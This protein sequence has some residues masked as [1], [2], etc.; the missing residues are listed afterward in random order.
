MKQVSHDDVTTWLAGQ[1][2]S[3][4]SRQLVACQIISP[5]EAFAGFTVFGYF[6][7]LIQSHSRSTDFESASNGTCLS[8]QSS[9]RDE[10]NSFDYTLPLC[11]RLNSQPSSEEFTLSDVWQSP[12]LCCTPGEK[13]CDSLQQS[14]HDVDSLSPKNEDRKTCQPNLDQLKHVGGIQDELKNDAQ[15]SDKNWSE[16]DSEIMISSHYLLKA[17]SG[18]QYDQPFDSSC[19]SGQNICLDLE[20]A[21]LSE[22]V[23]DFVSVEPQLSEV[24]DAKQLTFSD[25]QNSGKQ[26]ANNEMLKND[27]PENLKITTNNAEIPKTPKVLCTTRFSGQRKRNM[28]LADLNMNFSPDIVH[29]P[30]DNRLDRKDLTLQRKRLT[31][32]R[33][34]VAF[35]S[36]NHE[37]GKYIRHCVESEIHSGKCKVKQEQILCDDHRDTYNCSA[38]LFVSCQN[39]TD[40]DQSD[41]REIFKVNEA[42]NCHTSEPGVSGAL[43]FSP[44]LQSTPVSYQHA[45]RQ[46]TERSR[47]RVESLYS[48]R[49]ELEFNSDVPVLKENGQNKP[50]VTMSEMDQ[51]QIVDATERFMDKSDVQGNSSVNLNEW[52]RDL[53]E[54]SF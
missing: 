3:L 20:N 48:K 14:G 26:N 54:N 5:S 41:V 11:A 12:G 4:K 52:S 38:D 25:K 24:T 43:P 30:K 9:Q 39:S 8:Q 51:L 19:H 36:L 7:N 2:S 15:S 21:P 50:K 6:K 13:S 45:F 33:L 29:P 10:L 22:N 28:I 1:S 27:C 34:S 42:K 18:E 35:C 37:E 16:N 47:V 49:L 53:F 40:M 17:L 23:L 44:R 31:R 32:H 46:K